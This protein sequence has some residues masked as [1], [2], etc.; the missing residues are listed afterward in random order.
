MKVKKVTTRS[1]DR[2]KTKT[3]NKKLPPLWTYD[4]ETDPFL[5]GRVPVPFLFCAVCE[6]GRKFVAWG[7]NC[8]NDFLDF[9]K[10]EGR[11]LFIGHHGGKFDVLFLISQISG[12]VLSVDGRVLKC[13]IHK[14]EFRDSVAIL[15]MPLAK[16]DQSAEGKLKIKIEK[17]EKNNRDANRDEI[18]RYCLRDC[19][20]LLRAVENFYAMAGKR[21]LTIASVASTELRKFYP[22]LPK[23][24]QP[25]IGRSHFED[26]KQFFYGGRVG[27]LNGTGEFKGDFKLYDVNSMYPSV[28]ANYSH[29]FGTSYK[30]LPYTEA[31]AL[32]DKSCGFFRG[33]VN[34]S[35]C[36][37]VRDEKGNTP[38]SVGRVSVAITLHELRMALKYNLCT[39]I[40]GQLILSQNQ[41]N[42]EKFIT[43]FYNARLKAK[44]EFNSAMELFFK[45]ILNSSYGRFAMSPDG[46]E[47]TVVCE[48]EELEFLPEGGA[49]FEGEEFCVKFTDV[50]NEKIILCRPVQRQHQFY[51]DVAT[52]ASITGA[53]RAV[54]MEAIH[55]SK[56]ALYCDTDS[57]LCEE[58]FLPSNDKELGGWKLE[59][60]CDRVFIGGKK[61]YALYQKCHVVKKACKGVR[62]SA[63]KIAIVARGG[64]VSY[65]KD[66]PAMGLTGAKFIERR[67]RMT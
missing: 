9:V 32:D 23:I 28:M 41:T 5:F 27:V 8:V 7:D 26:F 64:V 50:V 1:R 54:L 33:V 43:H 2:E 56:T 59:A 52:G 11:A 58:L 3:E 10:N 4:C 49:M 48:R 14:A 25:K 24:N 39:V 42:F 53:A 21:A 66:A 51:E 18:S 36:F 45:L 19:D 61:L 63:K 44:K 22:D 37:P 30:I 15:P 29:P 40:S 57:L 17:L 6:D 35:G 60:E 67:I 13:R 34:S 12:R 62:I 31:K 46:R 47:E 16:L 20:V 38:Y 55:L 65:R